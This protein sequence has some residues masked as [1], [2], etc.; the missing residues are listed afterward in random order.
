MQD[1]GRA[2]D[3]VRGPFISTW[4]VKDR[5]QLPLCSDSKL[6]CAVQWGDGTSNTLTAFDQPGAGHTYSQPGT[7]TITV[8]GLMDGFAFADKGDKD[9]LL[10]I[11]Q[12]GIVQLGKEAFRGCSNFSATAKDAPD[13]SKVNTIPP[14]H[15]AHPPPVYHK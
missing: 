7:Y 9:L 3:V 4:K 2:G 11:S 14:P 5:V 13:L 6:N 8:S 12:W 1:V 10:D 15:P